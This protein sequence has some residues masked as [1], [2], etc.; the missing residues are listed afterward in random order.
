MIP[1]KNLSPPQRSLCIVRMLGRRKMQALGA[2]WERELS[3]ESFLF[4]DYFIFFI[5]MPSGILCGGERQK[6]KAI[7]QNNLKMIK[8]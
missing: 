8:K 6:R 1:A 4:F 5:G 3:E 7:V 2:R